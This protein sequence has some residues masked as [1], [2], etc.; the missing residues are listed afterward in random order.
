MATVRIQTEDF[1]LNVEVA[2]LRAR[3]PKIGALA[4]FVGT[5]RDL[6]EG[7]SVAAMALEHYPGMT[8]KALEKIAA[9]AGRRWPG[10]DV[11]I[12]HRVGTLLPLDQIVMVATVASHRGD[13]FASCEF[14]M[15][16]LKTEAP[17]WKK[18]TTP[19]GERWVD[20]R[21]TDDAAL[22]RWGIESGNTRR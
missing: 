2:A 22:A 13:A 4:C 21:S 18:E 19:D 10:I 14:V 9:E 5:V 7:D 15:D 11:A 20:A 1:D 8:E 17:F 6:N 12:V 3:N 16:Y